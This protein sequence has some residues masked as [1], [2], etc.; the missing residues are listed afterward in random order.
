M[1]VTAAHVIVHDNKISATIQA[2]FN[3]GNDDE[4]ALKP[5]VIGID[6]DR[7]VAFLRIPAKDLPEPLVLAPDAPIAETMDVV[8]A[9]FPY[10]GVLDR[11]QNPGLTISKGGISSVR[12]GATDSAAVIQL[13]ANVNPGKLG[14]SRK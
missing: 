13:D 5:T 2:Y 1:I 6:Q 14:R 3:S 11:K 12:M 9:G 8:L 4:V 7:D 10:G